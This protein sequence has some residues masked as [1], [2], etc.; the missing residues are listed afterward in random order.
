MDLHRFVFKPQEG[1]HGFFGIWKCFVLVH[2]NM[3]GVWRGTC[4]GVWWLR[5]FA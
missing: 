5:P 3:L 2:M 1:L 4:G